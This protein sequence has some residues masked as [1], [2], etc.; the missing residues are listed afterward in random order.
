MDLL[1]IV[2]I[3]LINLLSFVIGARIGQKVANDEKIEINPAM[4]V[5]E[6]IQEVKEINQE[7][8]D[9]KAKEEEDE[10]YNTIYHNI[11]VFDG[12]SNGQKTV[13]IKRK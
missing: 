13:P 3:L 1:T 10:Y 9:R 2:I 5:H 12:T 8:K 4:A 11:D 6:A 7:E